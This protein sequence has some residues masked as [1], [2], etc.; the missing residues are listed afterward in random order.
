MQIII[1]SIHHLFYSKTIL[2][3]SVIGN[4]MMMVGHSD[5]MMAQSAIVTSDGKFCEIFLA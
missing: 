5:V 1:C 4:L 3:L 2:A